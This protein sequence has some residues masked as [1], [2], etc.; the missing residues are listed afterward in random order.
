MHLRE[1]QQSMFKPGARATR[2]TNL[3]EDEGRALT[4]ISAGQHSGYL[5]APLAESGH[6]AWFRP[7]HNGPDCLLTQL[8][9]TLPI[10]YPPNGAKQINSGSTAVKNHKTP[11]TE[12]R[13]IG[14]VW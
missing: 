12:S 9:A 13:T 5:V 14:R 4:D 2:C 7:P 8:G 3:A 10:P 1:A 11:G 6:P